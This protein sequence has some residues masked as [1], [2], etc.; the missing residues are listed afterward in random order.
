VEQ[1][2]SPT[3]STEPSAVEAAA[4][5]RWVTLSRRPRADDLDQEPVRPRRVVAQL[6]AGL[7]AVLVAV[8]LLA[9]LAAQRLAE[10]EA[11]SDAAQTADV[12]A[13]AV[14]SPSLTNALADGDPSAVRSFDAV[15]RE[16]VL[17]DGVVRVKLWAPDGRVVYADEPQLVGRVFPLTDEQ[18]SALAEPRTRAEVSNLE[19]SENEFETGGRLLEVYRPVWT[20]DGTELLFEIYSAYEPVEQRAGQL[21]RGFTGVTVSSLLLVVAL[22]TPIVWRLLRRLVE[23]QRQRERWLERAV[24]ASDAERRRIAGSLHDG[25]VQE[26]V[27]TSF[28]AAGAAARAEA[29]SQ[30]ALAAELRDLATGLRGN[31]KVLRSLLVDIYPPSLS[32][33]G[34]VAALSDLAESTRGRG[35]TVH[36]DLHAVPDSGADGLGLSGAD[37]RLVYRVV[38]ECLRNAVTHAAPCT[39]TVSLGREDGALVLDVVDDG[40]GFDPAAHWEPRAGHFG[41]LVLSDLATEAGATLQVASAPGRGTHWRL[42]LAADWPPSTGGRT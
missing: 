19:A 37:Q 15:V 1:A 32:D 28:A 9:S 14:V 10:R 30:P 8:G 20:P 17:G 21:W 5:A 18:R 36:L 16:R 24:D 31:V 6:V 25:P 22:M 3:A 2:T 35:V 26:L 40:P 4:A 38:Q 13:N 42:V 29:L 11:V 23:A 7:L 41:V 39:A 27:A 12:L 33:A 34:L